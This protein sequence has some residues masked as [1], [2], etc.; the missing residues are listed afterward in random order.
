MPHIIIEHSSNLTELTNMHALVESVHQ[1]VLRSGLAEVSALRTRAAPRFHYRIAD[2]NPS[3]G[4][5]AIYARMTPGRDPEAIKQLLE[6]LIDTVDEV[7]EPL[8]DTHPVAISAEAQ[9]IDPA[10]RL[11]RNH[12]RA[13]SSK[14][15]SV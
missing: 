9:M 4:F 2:G 14:N 6:I 8:C 11:N 13:H 7:L 1:A 10:M 3:Y 5:V 12:I 15:R